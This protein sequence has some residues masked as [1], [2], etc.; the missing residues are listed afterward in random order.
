[1]PIAGTVIGVGTIPKGKW[2]LA[3]KLN[4]AVDVDVQLYDMDDPAC[5]DGKA[6]IAYSDKRDDPCGK[7]VLGNNFAEFGA[8]EQTVYKG[9]AISYSGYSGVD[10]NLGKEYI[11]IE[12]EVLTT[13]QMKAFA[14]LAGSAVISYEHG[15]SQTAVC[16]GILPREGSF[17]EE[18]PEGETVVIGDI[19]VGK[20]NLLVKLA[21]EEDVDIQLYDV[22][23]KAKESCPDNGQA[24]VA[25]SEED[26]TCA[27]GALGNNDGKEESTTYAGLNFTYSGYYGGQ[28]ESTYGNEWIKI[29]GVT[30]TVLTMKAFGFA[31][32]RSTISYEFFD[33]PPANEIPTSPSIHWLAGKNKKESLTNNFVGTPEDT[34]IVRRG[35]SFKSL[36]F[37]GDRAITKEMITG[38]I[39]GKVA[40]ENYRGNPRELDVDFTVQ[41]YPNDQVTFD[42]HKDGDNRYYITGTLLS[43]APA[44]D[45]ELTVTIDEPDAILSLR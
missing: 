28:T 30:N 18:V 41:D 11:I 42:V 36:I 22:G 33:V 8:K 34:I 21:S 26:N 1:M 9:M 29:D 24:I 3:I 37:C 39:T 31:A 43:T 35:D 45:Y 40:S 13:L 2:N 16:L 4:S 12:G 23:D 17:T 10:G 19:A 6:I 14:F 27:K 25:Y 20:K 15:F 38:K 7:G 5:P 32:G 44:G